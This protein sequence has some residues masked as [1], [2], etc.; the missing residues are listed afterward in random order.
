MSVCVFVCVGV[1]VRSKLSNGKVEPSRPAYYKSTVSTVF[2]SFFLCFPSL[3]IFRR[4]S[5]NDGM[6]IIFHLHFI[7]N[8]YIETHIQT[9]NKSQFPD[10]VQFND[11][12]YAWDI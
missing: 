5:Q 3:T 12:S 6:S 8:A 4:L 9:A 1:C 11:V 10:I 2:F 7:W